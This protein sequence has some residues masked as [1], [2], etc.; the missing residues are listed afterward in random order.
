MIYL[1]NNTTTQTASSVF[2]AMKPYFDSASDTDA[3]AV[4]TAREGIAGLIGAARTDEIVFTRSGTESNYFAILGAIGSLHRN[5]IITTKVEHRSILT[6][7][8]RQ[9]TQGLRVSWLDVDED[10]VLDIDGIRSALNKDTAVVSIMLA[11][12]ETG[13]LFPVEQLA[14]IIKANSD[15]LFHV[16]G[17][18]AMGK[19]PINLKETEIDLFS[20]SGHKFY[21]PNS[22]GA[23]YIRNGV[24]IKVSETKT[25]P[26]NVGIGAAA[27][28]VKD[29]SPMTAIGEMRER[30]ENAILKNIP[31]V[32]VNG[33]G[34]AA[35]RLPNTSNISFENTNGEAIMARLEAAGVIVSTSSACSSQDHKASAV[36]QAMNIPY[37]QAMGAVTFSL[38]RSNTFGEVDKVIEILPGLVCELRSLGK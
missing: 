15:A 33:T 30:L 22:V 18:C 9:E 17:A 25:V 21:G 2:D 35:N 19:I 20:M 29:L 16:D 14:E 38:G 12:N 1:D 32:Y 24:N 34:D 13:I 28:F 31:N 4:E 11:H 7:C 8:E 23:L 27:E 6:L 36:L 26:E 5:H 37:V 10:G 3:K